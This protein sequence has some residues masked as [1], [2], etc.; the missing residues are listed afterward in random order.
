MPANSAVVVPTFATNNAVIDNTPARAPYLCR[1]SPARPCPVTTPIRAPRSWNSTNAMV[2]T[3][4]T[5]R[6]VYP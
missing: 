1:I 6:K 2:E 3:A 4:S 5:H